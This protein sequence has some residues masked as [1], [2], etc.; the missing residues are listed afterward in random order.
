MKSLFLLP[1]LLSVSVIQP[2]QAKA[3]GCY[4]NSAWMDFETYQAAGLTISQSLDYIFAEGL[5]NSSVKCRH[6]F[7]GVYNQY[8]HLAAFTHSR[9]A[10]W[11]SYN[12][13]HFD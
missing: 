8:N 11:S 2:Q 9:R 1:L 6:R 13:S 7:V 3:A 5:L 4:P 10:N 12:W